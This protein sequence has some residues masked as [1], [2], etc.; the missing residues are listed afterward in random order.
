L[1]EELALV[2]GGQAFLEP[3]RGDNLRI[4]AVLEEEGHIPPV[5]CSAGEL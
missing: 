3:D 1:E 5:S 2:I 4:C